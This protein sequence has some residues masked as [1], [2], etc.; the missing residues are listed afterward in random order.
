MMVCFGI[1]KSAVVGGDDG[2]WVIEQTADDTTLARAKDNF[3]VARENLFD[4]RLRD[5]L[6]FNVGVNEKQGELTNQDTT[7]R[8][9]A[10]THY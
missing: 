1:H 2:Y 10:N 5:N 3:A 4:D 7:D 6:D 9:L 8:G